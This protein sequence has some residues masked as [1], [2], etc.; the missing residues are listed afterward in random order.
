[1]RRIS[2]PAI[3]YVLAILATAVALYARH[4]L[5]PLLG[6]EN[7]YHTV[8]LAVVFSAW[9]CGVGPAILTT[10]LGAAGVWYWFLPP[11]SSWTIPDTSQLFGV[12]GFLVLSTVIIAL[13]ESSRR[14]SAT[15]ARLAAIVGSSD[16]AI[17]SKDLNGIMTSWNDAAQRLFGWTALEAVGRPVTILIPSD[18]LHEETEILRRLRAG[19]R[20][21]HFET[22]RV[23]KTGKKMEISLTV[24][25][26]RD[27]AG[28][29]IGASK[30]ARDISERIRAEA[31]LK[32][33]HDELEQRVKER[34][35]EL[36]EKNSELVNQAVLVQELSARLLR[37]QDDERR[38]IARELH[39]SVGQAL[40][41]L[42]M[43]LADVAKEKQNLSENAGKCVDATASLLQQVSQEVRTISHLLH[44]PLLD[45]VGLSSALKWYIDGFS[46]RSKIDVSLDMPE[47]FERLTDDLEISIFRIVQECLTNIHR[48]SESSKA[49]IRLAAEDGR[50][51]LEVRD[52]GKG[53]PPE[54]QASLNS[55]GAVGV[56]FRG[57]RERVRELGGTLEIRSSPAGTIVLATLPRPAGPSGSANG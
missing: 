6:N 51:R 18:R 53:I 46:E 1:V 47:N 56:G 33:A 45:E 48:H 28:R 12:L 30:I 8:W 3:R 34:T 50:I 55:S 26:I 10:L 7:P 42:G 35:A 17:I 4:L 25:P 5:T 43:N 38:R 39:D 52:E 20:I 49:A 57:M 2:H 22:V 13:G 23:S 32:V 11:A 41:I 16:D 24:S 37:L 19:Q 21:E 27:V 29:V 44:P 15:Q 9:Y 40:A 31:Q 36:R 54:K 14:A